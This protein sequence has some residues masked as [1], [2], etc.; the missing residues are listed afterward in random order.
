MGHF[1]VF[2]GLLLIGGSY[3]KFI[4]P[5]FSYKCKLQNPLLIFEIGQKLWEEIGF[6]WLPIFVQ[7]S[8]PACQMGHNLDLKGAKGAFGSYPSQFW[9]KISLSKH[10]GGKNQFWETARFDLRQALKQPSSFSR[11]SSNAHTPW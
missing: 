8:P 3:E 2:Q 9:L 1:E 11:Y 6:E 10:E 4:N 5:I 7:Y